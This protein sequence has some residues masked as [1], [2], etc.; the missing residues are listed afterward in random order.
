M[1]GQSHYAEVDRANESD[2]Q[3]WWGD[4]LCGIGDSDVER[5]NDIRYVTCKHCLKRYPKYKLWITEAMKTL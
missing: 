4:T 2:N 1:K 3:D 5:S